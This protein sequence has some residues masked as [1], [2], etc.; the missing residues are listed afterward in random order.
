MSKYFRF[1]LTIFIGIFL[2]IAISMF[3]FSFGFLMGGGFPLSM[4]D[5]GLSLRHYGYMMTLT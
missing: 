3:V 4:E 2:F 5:G 1:L